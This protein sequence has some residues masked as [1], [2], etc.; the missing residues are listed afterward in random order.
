MPRPRTRRTTRK[1]SVRKKFSI[2]TRSQAFE[3][4]H[5]RADPLHHVA[6]QENRSGDDD[7]GAR[8]STAASSAA[9][10]SAAIDDR[11][12]RRDRA[13]LLS[14]GSGSAERAFD[15]RVTISRPTCG[16]SAANMPL[17]VLVP[18]SGEHQRPLRAA[19]GSQIGRERGGA[20]RVVRRIEQQL[21]AV[22]EPA[23]LETAGP[24]GASQS[25]CDGATQARQCPR[26]QLAGEC[27][28]LRPRSRADVR[29]RGLIVIP[30]L[31]AAVCADRPRA[32]AR[33]DVLDRRR[34]VVLHRADDHRHAGL[35]DAGF[36]E[37]RSH[38]A[39]SR[40]T[41]GDRKRSR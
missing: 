38:A 6:E 7:A 15:A 3:A 9:P 25:C 30:S 14:Q 34:R 29:R 5:D 39:S 13:R 11:Q 17:D 32:T 41:S 33:G 16:S 2:Q 37:A 20:G 4:Y 22:R 19:I 27:P 21:A 10:R 31:S 18:H 24:L 28:A 23:H 40:D 8:S 36:F 26:R 1:K 12:R 35:D